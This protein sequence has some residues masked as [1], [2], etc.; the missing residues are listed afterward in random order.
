MRCS[1]WL[2][3]AGKIERAKEMAKKANELYAKK[4]DRDDEARYYKARAD[5]TIEMTARMS[6]AQ[7]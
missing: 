3:M 5:A 7:L 6:G 1:Y 2:M 4:S